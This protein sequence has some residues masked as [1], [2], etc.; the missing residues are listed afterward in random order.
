MLNSLVLLIAAC[1]LM[2]SGATRAQSGDGATFRAKVLALYSFQPHRLSEAEV[3]A[4]SADLDRFWESV[5]ANAA[6][7]L[8]LLRIEL[9]N[10]Q[11]PTFF[12]YDG[13][14]L[15]LSLSNEA[16]DRELALRSL[17][18]VDLRDVQHTDY[19]R[20][21]HSL[22][23]LG[24][25]TR[26]AALR[27]LEDPDFKAFIPLHALTLGQD[28][29]LIYM[30]YAQSGVSFEADLVARLRVE[31]NPKAQRSLLLALWYLTTPTSRDAIASFS[32]RSDI[33]GE[34]ATYARDLL[35]RNAGISI[36]LKS[37]ESLRAER[38][39]VMQRPISDEA[40]IEFDSL[41][42]KLLAK[43]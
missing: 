23:R 7:T 15:L 34:S 3:H 43:L 10:P 22:A 37:S 19:L 2:F 11:N 5:K 25:D 31:R 6:G 38:V 18:K 13:A 29:C 4:K 26:T 39:K 17:P 24:L 32:R 20:T 1:A 8:P 35:S 42:F 41:T 16:S 28:Y 14:K 33:S 27:I 30:L 12:F 9:E 21:V 36:S 40:L